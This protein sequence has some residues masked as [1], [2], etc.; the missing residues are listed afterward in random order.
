MAKYFGIVGAAAT[1]LMPGFVTPGA[2]TPK[3]ANTALTK[4]AAWKDHL[5]LAPT[6]NTALTAP[7]NAGGGMTVSSTT[8]LMSG[9]ATGAATF[10]SVGS[11]CL[12]AAYTKATKVQ[13][14]KF[15]G[16]LKRSASHKYFIDAYSV[17]GAGTASTR[18]ASVQLGT[19]AGSPS[20]WLNPSASFTPNST[21][22]VTVPAGGHLVMRAVGNGG[23]SS[24]IK[25]TTGWTAGR[26]QAAYILITTETAAV[27]G[28]PNVI[29]DRYNDSAGNPVPDG[30]KVYEYD[31]STM[32][33]TGNVG[34]IGG[35]AVGVPDPLIAPTATGVGE[36]VFTHT[37]ADLTEY[38]YVI[39]DMANGVAWAATTA[40]AL[41]AKMNPANVGK[42]TAVCTVAGTTGA[43]EPV[44]F[45]LGLVKGSTVVDGTVTWTMEDTE[46]ICTASILS[47]QQWHWTTGKAVLNASDAVAAGRNTNDYLYPLIADELLYAYCT[48]SGT[49][50]ATE[51]TWASLLATAGSAAA[52]VGTLVTDGTAVWTIGIESEYQ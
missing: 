11:F 39:P 10:Y 35:A 26:L 1:T 32:Q 43:T 24:G 37:V 38:F 4:N 42:L 16:S 2:A 3:T 28:D 29:R 12:G 51:P 48:T 30:V 19:Y 31:A 21:K 40:V 14:D 45:N 41:G 22:V 33:P 6:Q 47:R 49:T 27:T 52:L 8:Q 44:W 34:V 15:R 20:G 50:G 7:A 23:T 13:I 36:V 25:F 18:V 17:N 46:T 9:I 5:I